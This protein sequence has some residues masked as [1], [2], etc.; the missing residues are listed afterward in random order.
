M[1][2]YI[3]FVVCSLSNTIED[4]NGI[5]MLLYIQLYLYIMILKTNNQTRSFGDAN[6]NFTLIS[7]ELDKENLLL[8]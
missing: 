4:I 8:V 1:V 3:L 7:K 6:E 5:F 2:L